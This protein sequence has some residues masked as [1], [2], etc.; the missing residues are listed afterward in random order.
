MSDKEPDDL[1]SGTPEYSIAE[2]MDLLHA[3]EQNVRHLIKKAGITIDESKKDP[4]ETILYK[5]F[6]T[7]WISRANRRE[8]RLLATLLIEESDNWLNRHF[9]KKGRQ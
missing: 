1:K 3:D 2:I 9:A 7:L 8:G 6:R 5:D 4:S